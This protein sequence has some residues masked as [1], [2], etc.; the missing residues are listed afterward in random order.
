MGRSRRGS[1]QRREGAEHGRRDGEEHERRQRAHTSGNDRRTGRRRA[2]AS[3]RR[4]RAARASVASRSSTGASGSPSRSAPAIEAARSRP[5]GPSVAVSSSSGVG[6]RAPPVQLEVDG[7]E[8]PPD[9]RRGSRRQLGDRLVWRAPGVDAEHQQLDGVGHR[10]LH[11][12]PHALLVAAPVAHGDGGDGSGSQAERDRPDRDERPVGRGRRRAPRRPRGESAGG[13]VLLT[14]EAPVVVAVAAGERRRSG[15]ARRTWSLRRSSPHRS[16][17]RSLVHPRIMRRACDLGTRWAPVIASPLRGEEGAVSLELASLAHPTPPI[18]VRIHHQPSPLSAQPAT[19]ARGPRRCGEDVT[20]RGLADHEDAEDTERHQSSGPAPTAGPGRCSSA[21][22]PFGGAG[23]QG[24]GDPVQRA[25][26]RSAEL[27]GGDD[28]RC[29][30]SDGAAGT[31]RT[32]TRAPRP[33]GDR[34]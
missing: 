21:L 9:R 8:G 14:R 7:D 4:R 6:E 1:P 29:Q 24:V 16:P 11:R 12:A 23:Q 3:P 15:T 22:G 2:A 32:R 30:Q 5:A 34:G 13:G 33:A 27:G 17:C 28:H 19:S 31:V 26:G 18:S 10:L 20:D 25:R